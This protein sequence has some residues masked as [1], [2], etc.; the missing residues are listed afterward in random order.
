MTPEQVDNSEHYLKLLG[1]DYEDGDAI[2]ETVA[3]VF[4]YVRELETKLD[5]QSKDQIRKN[6]D[7]YHQSWRR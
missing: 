5:K 2:R 1:D 7:D 3:D 4:A 6:L